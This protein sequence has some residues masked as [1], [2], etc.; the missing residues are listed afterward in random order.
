MDL[1]LQSPPRSANGETSDRVKFPGT[2]EMTRGGSGAVIG[3]SKSKEPP[4]SKSGSRRNSLLL[5]K[6]QWRIGDLNP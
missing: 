4:W 5:F 6:L 2:G 1:E 3:I